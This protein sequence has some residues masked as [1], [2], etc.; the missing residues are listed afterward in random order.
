MAMQDP[1]ALARKEGRT[2]LTEVEAK[3]VLKEAGLNVVETRLARSKAE[4]Q[5]IAKEIGFPV[6]L[7]ILSPDIVHKSDI[8]GV[9][10]GARERGGGGDGLR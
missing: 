9:R 1:V 3:Q 4:A 10:L 8:G 6:V 5:S 2:L 7:K